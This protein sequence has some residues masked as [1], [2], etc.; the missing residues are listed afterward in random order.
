M[1]E[2]FLKNVS[3]I[4]ESIFGGSAKLRCQ[5]CIDHI[6][7]QCTI[8]FCPVDVIKVIR[9]V[10]EEV[11][12]D[13]ALVMSVRA[14]AAYFLITHQAEDCNPGNSGFTWRQWISAVSGSSVESFASGHLLVWGMWGGDATTAALPIALGT[15]VT[16]VMVDRGR[17]E[18]IEGN[19]KEEF[20]HEGGLPIAVMHKGGHYDLLLSKEIVDR[21]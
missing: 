4:P 11:E 15:R 5:D 20:G 9:R 2:V 16:A 17:C 7:A 12:N 6:L 13:K 10:F 3:E 14:L 19:S 21:L 18:W 1:L 8:D